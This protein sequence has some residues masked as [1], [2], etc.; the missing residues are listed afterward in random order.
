MISAEGGDTNKLVDF[1]KGQAKERLDKYTNESNTEPKSFHDL[2]FNKEIE[3]G[4]GMAISEVITKYMQ[5]NKEITRVFDKKIPLDYAWPII[6]TYGAEGIGFGSSFPELTVVMYRN[7]YEN[8]DA[9]H[10]AEARAYGLDIPVKPDVISYEEREMSVHGI[11][12]FYTAKY[13]PELVKPLDLNKY[14]NA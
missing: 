3:T 6:K 14:L 5:G 8:I 10:W 4:I 7:F 1:M 2:I 12:A 11:V 9:N 13:W